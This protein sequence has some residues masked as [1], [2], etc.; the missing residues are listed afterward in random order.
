MKYITRLLLG[1]FLIILA[2]GAVYV[3][4]QSFRLTCFESEGEAVCYTQKRLYGLIPISE[5]KGIRGEDLLKICDPFDCHLEY[6]GL[7][8]YVYDVHEGNRVINFLGAPQEDPMQVYFINMPLSFSGFVFITMPGLILGVVL[9]ASAF[10]G[11]VSEE[12]TEAID[13][14]ETDSALTGE[15]KDAVQD[16]SPFLDP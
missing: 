3:F 8:K 1:Y 9:I 7:I 16:E 12:T 5:K 4:G 2:L 6:Q 10:N 11:P 14:P 15:D 13:D